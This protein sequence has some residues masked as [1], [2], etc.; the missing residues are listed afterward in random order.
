MTPGEIEPALVIPGELRAHIAPLTIKTSQP[1]EI[2]MSAEKIEILGKQVIEHILLERPY[3]KKGFKM[4]ELAAN[5]Q[6]QPYILSAVI[7]RVFKE[8][9]NDFMNAYRVSHAKTLLKNGDARLLKLEAISEQCGFNNRN[10]FTTA[11]KKHS[12]QTPSD[13]IKNSATRHLENQT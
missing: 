2:Y 8:N 12:G 5:L 7:N 9:Y 10:S 13:F 1:K 3:L 6:M 4:P 11:F